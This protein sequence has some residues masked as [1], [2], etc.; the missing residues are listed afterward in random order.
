MDTDKS[1]LVLPFWGK[2]SLTF[3]AVFLALF[4]VSLHFLPIVAYSSALKMEVADFFSGL[5]SL[6][7]KKTVIVIV[8]ALRTSDLT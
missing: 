2:Y 6:T 3:A 8:T 4:Y 5:H 1:C 7:S